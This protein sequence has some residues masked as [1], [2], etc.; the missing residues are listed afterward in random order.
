MSNPQ[1]PKF[2]A[3]RD[4]T[5]FAGCV[6]S[7]SAR[8]GLREWRVQRLTASRSFRSGSGSSLQSAVGRLD[9]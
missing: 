4:D 3:L 8:E 2:T 1:L 6:S 9:G 7:R 5:V